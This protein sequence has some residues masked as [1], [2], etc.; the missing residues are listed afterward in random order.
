MSYDYD[1]YLKF[2]VK[3][4]NDN[5]TTPVFISHA[6]GVQW[7]L[8]ILLK[9][10]LDSVNDEI[11]I[12]RYFQVKTKNYRAKLYFIMTCPPSCVGSSY[13]IEIKTHTPSSYSQEPTLITSSETKRSITF[14]RCQGI[15]VYHK[16]FQDLFN[17]LRVVHLSVRVR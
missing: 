8:S 9:S 11:T 12:F 10:K 13:S 15:D 16:P 6:D 5:K 2:S 3:S 4:L 7:Y 17:E 14:N 1:S